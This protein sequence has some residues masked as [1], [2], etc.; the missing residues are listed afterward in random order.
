VKWLRSFGF[1]VLILLCLAASAVAQTPP[2]ESNSSPPDLTNYLRPLV[3]EDANPTGAETGAFSPTIFLRNLVVSN[4]NANLTNTDTFN[5][6]EPSIAINPNDPDEI[7]IL[8]FSGSWGANAP[9]WHTTDGGNTW[10]KLSTIPNPDPVNQAGCPCDQAPD[11]GT[12]GILAITF[13]VCPNGGCNIMTGQ[14]TDPTNAAAWQWSNDGMVPAELINEPAGSALNSDQPWLLINVDPNNPNQEIIHN[15]YDD[16]SAGPAMQVS[17]TPS[18]IPANFAGQDRFVGSSAPFV[19]PG[20]RQAKDPRTGF[21]YSAWQVE[22]NQDGLDPKNINFMLN[23]STDGGGAGGTW[24]LNGVATGIVV[25]NA[26]SSQPRPKFGTVNALLG[27]VLHV[28]VDPNLGHVYYVYGDRNPITGNDRLS[29]ARLQDDGMGNL[30]VASDTLLTGEVEAAIPSVAITNDGTVGVFYYTFDGFSSVSFPI[31][32]AW[33]ALSG[34]QGVTFTHRKLLTFLSSAQDDGV[35]NS[36]QRVLGDYVQMK[37]LGRTFYGTFTG[38]G[39]PFGRPISNHDPYFFRETVGPIINI[40]APTDFG[41][42]CAGEIATKKIEIS[43]TG[44][45]PLVLQNV[46]KLSGDDDIQL[47]DS[48]STPQTIVPGAELG[49]DVECA[50]STPGLKTATIRIESNDPDQPVVDLDYSCNVGAPT[51]NTTL[52]DNGHFGDVCRGD[53]AD[54]TLQILNEG[55]C[56]L[57]VT[58]IALSDPANFELPAGTQIPLNLQSGSS[59]DIPIRFIPDPGQACGSVIM[60]TVTVDSDDPSTPSVVLDVSGRVPCP[61][62]NVAIANSGSFGAVCKGG[63]SDLDLTLF[64]QGKCDLTISGISSDNVNFVLPGDLDL[65]LIL[66]PDADFNLPVRFAPNPAEACDNDTPREG[67]ITIGSDSPG[68]EMKEI[69]VSGVVPCPNLVIDPAGL[70]DIF[71]FP[72]TVA[73]STGTLGCSAD[74]SLTLR[75]NGAC[76]L[77]ISGIN[78]GGSLDFS[79]LGPTQFPVTLPPGEETLAVNVRFTPQSGGDPMT[80]DEILGTLTVTSDDPDALG[81]AALCGEGVAQSGMR[82]L[83]TDVTAGVPSI[84]GSVDDLR[85]SSKGKGT[86]GPIQF[87]FRNQTPSSE[88]VC[89]NTVNYHVD[90]EVLPTAATT[91]NNPKASYEVRAKEGQM[92]SSETFQIGQCDFLA[93]QVQLTSNGGSGNGKQ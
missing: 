66:S 50:A 42:L 51:I 90:L 31:F 57:N 23:R 4:T 9:L 32:T 30:V 27:G 34:D 37:A 73:D 46:S 65:P 8:A 6:G 20:H 22:L 14:T 55:S 44:T 89:G 79:V 21:I 71:A 13:L 43:N 38:N 2:D 75:N 45:D 5:D 16:F 47:L 74:R 36:R 12:S 88:M 69:D 64:N 7:V 87:R 41:E 86:P 77:M 68:E 83:V 61:D 91:G 19:N 78:T 54:L 49:F 63:A 1:H 67:T 28:A 33:L 11:W 35:A 82:L 39:A 92:Q 72:I 48:P 53:H 40:E 24:G 62:F 3:A 25:A 52:V 56:T 29:I 60:A 85:V 26:S 18:G 10:S 17:S 76:P 58:D 93:M 59:A 70:T 15:A 81:Q 84:I 80:P